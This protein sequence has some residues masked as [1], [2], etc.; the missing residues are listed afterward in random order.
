MTRRSDWFWVIGAAAVLMLAAALS[1]PPPDAEY[2]P[3]STY[4]NSDAGLSLVYQLL[5]ELNGDAP[6]VQWKHG[7][8]PAAGDVLVAWMPE[9]ISRA[10]WRAMKAWAREGRTLV[11]GASPAILHDL[12][13][14]TG[15]FYFDVPPARS[16]QPA[17]PQRLS[18]LTAGLGQV[19]IPDGYPLF[20]DPEWVG[21]VERELVTAQG[22]AVAVS[23][24]E[25][26]GRIVIFADPHWLT[27][28]YLE[29]GDNLALAL[30]LFSGRQVFFDEYHHGFQANDSRWSVASQLPRL[31][32]WQAVLA[33]LLYLLYRSSRF[34]LPWPPPAVAPRQAAEF[35]QAMGNLYRQA[36]ARETVVAAAKRQI[37]Q[38]LYR[39]GA[40]VRTAA[41]DLG[42]LYA[43]RTG[44]PAAELTELL[45]TLETG[46]PQSERQVLELARRAELAQRRMEHGR[47][48][49]TH[50]GG[51]GA[52]TGEPGGGRPGGSA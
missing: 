14:I 32:M 42:R 49:G 31:L 19:M 37:M 16:V 6:P 15:E 9:T 22:H 20:G 13:E 46:K 34:G 17:R 43:A 27:N 4:D 10:E 7:S 12:D 44:R 33:A 28:G 50:R 29:Q 47:E 38:Q 36:R 18:P 1:A 30:R 51:A 5:G 40:G 45:A 3:F 26:D 2:P 25:G 23:W 11:L 52:G 35:A 41:D 8:L 39:M 48:R 24:A 21:A